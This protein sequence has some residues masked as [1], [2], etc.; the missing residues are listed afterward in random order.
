MLLATSS[1]L[2]N[3]IDARTQRNLVRGRVNSVK[4]YSQVFI[5]HSV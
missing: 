1:Q 2:T 4:G 3:M 5:K